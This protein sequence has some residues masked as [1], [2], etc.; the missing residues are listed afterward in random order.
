MATDYIMRLVEQI[1]ATLAGILFKQSGG[2]YAEARDDL[3]EKCVETIGMGLGDVIRLS[4]EG[5]AELLAG[6][7]AL[8]CSRSILLA[9]LL[10]L[11]SSLGDALRDYS[12]S[13]LDYL[14]AF[15]L[16]SDSLAV[17]EPEDQ[18]VYRA[19]ADSLAVRLRELPSSTYIEEKLRRYEAAKA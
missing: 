12:R 4:P 13:S 11:D 6:A 10:L 14:H 3:D 2:R 15:C 5:V 19:K 18:A 8:R 7:G 9:E 17:L 16:L 1:A